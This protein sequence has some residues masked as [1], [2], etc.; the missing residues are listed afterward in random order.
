MQNYLSETIAHKFYEFSQNIKGKELIFGVLEIE[1]SINKPVICKRNCSNKPTLREGAVYYR[2]NSK[3]EE[4]K[5]I[6]LIR[7]IQDE[8]DKER[9]LWVKNISQMA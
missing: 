7:I 8:K 6:D 1:E 2:Y 5:A 4:I 9:D 3:S